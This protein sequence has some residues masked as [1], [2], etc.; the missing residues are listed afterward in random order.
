MTIAEI[1]A[2]EEHAE[3]GFVSALIQGEVLPVDQSTGR[4]SIYKS[5]DDTTAE[6][7]RIEVAIVGGRARNEHKYRFQNDTQ[8][9][10]TYEAE[11]SV[12]VVTNRTSD[13]TNPSHIRVLGLVRAALQRCVLMERWDNPVVGVVDCIE[14][15]TNPTI[16]AEENIDITE[17][18]WQLLLQIRDSIWPVT[19]I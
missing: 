13:A 7:P 2:Y 17:I 4:R 9:H 5:R 3:D 1:L 12:L 18:S 11:L 15:G 6:T 19:P 14:T 16:S 10:N 8:I